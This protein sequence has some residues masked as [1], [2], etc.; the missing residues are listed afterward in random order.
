VTARER[1]RWAEYRPRWA[2]E[3][4]AHLHRLLSERDPGFLAALRSAECQVDDE[5]SRGVG[6]MAAVKELTSDE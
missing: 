6:M 2:W 4:T 1:V 5:L 3:H